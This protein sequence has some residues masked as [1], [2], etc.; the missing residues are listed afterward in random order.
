MYIYIYI[1]IYMSIYLSIGRSQLHHHPE[2]RV[3]APPKPDVESPLTSQSSSTHLTPWLDQHFSACWIV[4]QNG[5]LVVA[6]RER[7]CT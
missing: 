7:C 6:Q 1:N 2:G 3:N 5:W 4:T